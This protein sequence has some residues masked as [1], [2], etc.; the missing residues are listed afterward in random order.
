M[1]T[2]AHSVMS[3]E[4]CWDGPLPA[5][6][7]SRLYKTNDGPLPLSPNSGFPSL[8]VNSIPLV[9]QDQ[10]MAPSAAQASLKAGD[11]KTK[12]PPAH[13]A[14]PV[15]HP[16]VQEEE[17]ELPEVRT[18]H[19]EPLKLSGALDKYE[20]FDVTP[21][22]GREYPTLDLKE[23]LRAPNSDEL[24]R[25]LAITSTYLPHSRNQKRLTPDRQ[26][27]SAA[28]SSSGSRTTSTT[29]S[30]RSSSSA[31][32]RS[33]ASRRRPACTSTRSTTRRAA[34]TTTTRSA[35]SPP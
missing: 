16:Q 20:H 15:Q 24:V 14:L 30:R 17:E 35:S 1:I 29:T 2:F 33:R 19:R 18:G 9:N 22:I 12:N 25:D 27:R 11:V 3:R 28:S 13:E 6:S 7:V 23:L 32:A 4:P 26:Y 5:H 34:T 21:I 8:R 31:S 10:K